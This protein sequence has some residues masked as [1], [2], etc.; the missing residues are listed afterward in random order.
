MSKELYITCIKVNNTTYFEGTNVGTQIL[1][2]SSIQH[3]KNLSKYNICIVEI[4]SKNGKKH[5]CLLGKK[6]KSL[7]LK[8]FRKL[9]V[10]VLSSTQRHSLFIQ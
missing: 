7:C 2:K 9:L 3:R 4:K 8:K 5:E 1:I 6:N 10:H